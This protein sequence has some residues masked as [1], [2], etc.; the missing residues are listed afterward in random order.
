MLSW[1]PWGHLPLMR[2]LIYA[3]SFKAILIGCIVALYDSSSTHMVLVGVCCFP[4]LFVFCFFFARS[5]VL[6]V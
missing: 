3:G 4:S 5:L 6:S 2:I 1:P